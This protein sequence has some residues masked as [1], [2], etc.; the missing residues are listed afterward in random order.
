MGM[1][2]IG[3]NAKSKVGEYFRNNVWW[4]RPLAR[5]VCM[6]APAITAHCKFWQSNDGDGLDGVQSIQLAKALRAEIS[7]GRCA[8]YAVERAAYI[9]ALP[10]KPCFL[11]DGSG[12]RADAIG[13]EHGQSTPKIESPGHPRDGQIGWCNGCDGRGDVENDEAH[14]PFSIENVEEFCAFLEQCGGFEIW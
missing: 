4:W 11:C 13:I 6:V 10:R 12:V 9:A 8:A 3:K 7:S 2:V 14:Y 1:D 5:Y